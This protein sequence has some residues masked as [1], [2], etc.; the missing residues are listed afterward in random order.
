M[1]MDCCRLLSA[2]GGLVLF[3]ALSCRVPQVGEEPTSPV[4]GSRSPSGAEMSIYTPEQHD[5]YSGHFL[6][7]AAKIYQVG[8]LN[9]PPGWDHMITRLETCTV[10]KVWS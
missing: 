4:V 5:R 7:E 2:M 1:T 8:S 9:D 3:S 10:W 6:I